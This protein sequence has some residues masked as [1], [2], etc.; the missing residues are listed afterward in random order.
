M[1]QTVLQNH[2]ASLERAAGRMVGIGL[3]G[4]TT[5]EGLALGLEFADA[6]AEEFHHNRLKR[7]RDYKPSKHSTCTDPTNPA[8]RKGVRSVWDMTMNGASLDGSSG[9]INLNTDSYNSIG[10]FDQRKQQQQEEE[11]QQQQQQDE[12]SLPRRGKRQRP[13]VTHLDL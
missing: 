7:V 6:L 4:R 10:D 9:L 11:E 1:F 8:W 5:G 12:A 13:A 2:A 3:L